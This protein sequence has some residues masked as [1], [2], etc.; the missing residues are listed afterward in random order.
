MRKEIKYF[1][2]IAFE[3]TKVLVLFLEDDAPELDGITRIS[4]PPTST[5]LDNI[6]EPDREQNHEV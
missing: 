5:P 6:W 2:F 3:N 4:T 1:D